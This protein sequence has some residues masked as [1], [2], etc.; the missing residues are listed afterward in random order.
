MLKDFRKFILR[1]NVV[2]LAVAVTVGTAF[3][4]MITAFVADMV[5][6]LIASIGGKHDFSKLYFELHNSK[7]L[8]GSFINAVITFLVTATV[9]FFLVVQPLNKLMAKFKPADAGTPKQRECPECKSN[10]PIDATRCM[11]CT[12]R[13][14]PETAST[15]KKATT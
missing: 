8:Y 9:V 1:G 4:A 6:P 2:D 11:Y 5:T 13:I 12:S 15:A 3:T 7:F 10:I 14:A